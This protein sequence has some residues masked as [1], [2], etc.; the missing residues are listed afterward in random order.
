MPTNL[1][2][3]AVRGSNYPVRFQF[4]VPLED[5]TMYP[6]V[7]DTATWTLR[8]RRGNIINEREDVAI[9]AEDLASDLTLTLYGDDLEPRPDEAVWLD[10]VRL[11]IVEATYTYNG[12]SGLPWRDWCRFIL[13]DAP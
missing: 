3:P 7:P 10:P 6:I 11:L 8:D 13:I 1:D 9:A 2:V 4:R 12:A 5:G